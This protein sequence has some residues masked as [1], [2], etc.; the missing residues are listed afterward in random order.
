M[1]LF[2]QFDW[3]STNRLRVYICES[4]KYTVKRHKRSFFFKK[5]W[6][7]KLG[8]RVID[9]VWFTHTPYP[10]VGFHIWLVLLW[11]KS[12]IIQVPKC[13]VGLCH[14][15]CSISGGTHSTNTFLYIGSFMVNKNNN[16][17]KKWVSIHKE[18]QEE[19]EKKK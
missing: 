13:F 2:V 5:N 15:K 10:L 3:I 8:S 7:N 17:R 6:S 16:S 18:N 11:P 4:T 9:D 14:F 1:L 12:S 19:D